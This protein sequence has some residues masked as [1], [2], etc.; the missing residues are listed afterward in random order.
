[1]EYGENDV[2][3]EEEEEEEQKEIDEEQKD[4]FIRLHLSASS[5]NPNENANVVRQ[6]MTT[7]YGFSNIINRVCSKQ[8][9]QVKEKRKLYLT[10]QFQQYPQQRLLSDI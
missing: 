9:E 6:W 2:D 8:L 3:T 5:R 4:E 7:K 10:V 1:M